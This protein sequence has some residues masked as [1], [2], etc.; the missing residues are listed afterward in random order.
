[1]GNIVDNKGDIISDNK[2]KIGC[3]RSFPAGGRVDCGFYFQAGLPKVPLFPREGFR[4]SSLIINSSNY[5]K[6]DIND[7]V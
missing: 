4:V 6:T 3:A 7:I 1:M 2:G 5:F